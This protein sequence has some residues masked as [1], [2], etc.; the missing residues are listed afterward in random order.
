[1]KSTS[2]DMDTVAE[3]AVKVGG[4]MNQSAGADEV[5]GAR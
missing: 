2:G 5:T 1:M 4:W 3:M